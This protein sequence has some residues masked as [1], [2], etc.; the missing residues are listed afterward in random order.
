MTRRLKI[1]ICQIAPV[2]GDIAGNVAKILAA[3]A[4]AATAGA[5]LA[6]FCEL[7]VCGYPP[8]DLVAKPAFQ[9]ACRVA[10]EELARAC[11]DGGPAM[12]V[13]AP[14]REGA[15]LYNAALLLDG[16]EIRLLLF[17]RCALLALAQLAG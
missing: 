7:V 9:R 14:W 12:I 5:D 8:E 1:A 2:V 16:G 15:A 13:G 6:V 3:R 4:D 10:V 11:R 17:A